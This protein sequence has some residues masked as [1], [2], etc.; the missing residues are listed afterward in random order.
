MTP[1]ELHKILEIG[2][3]DRV[4]FKSSINSSWDFYPRT[5]T[6]LEDISIEKVQK[7]IE[8]IR[9]RNNSAMMDDPLTFLQ[10]GRL[11]SGE[12][13][14][15][16]CWLLFMPDSDICTTIELGR[17]ESPT[18]ISDSVTLKEDL[19]SEVDG[20]LHFIRRHINKRIIITGEAENTERWDYP[21]EAIRELVI[22][23]I[24]HRDYT[25]PYDSIVK[26][27]DDRIEFFNPGSLPE[28]ISLEQLWSDQYVSMPRN[29]L[30]AEVFK[31]MGLIEKYGSGIRRVINAMMQNQLQP[32][33][34]ESLKNGFKVTLFKSKSHLKEFQQP[35]WLGEKL[36]N[37]LGDFRVRLFSD[38]QKWI[39]RLMTENP[40]ISLAEMSRQIG[41]SQTAV[42]KNIK[43]LKEMGAIRREGTAKKGCWKV[44][45]EGQLN[46]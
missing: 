37:R 36:G 20:V 3:T 19:I 12:S 7:T 6:R 34:F 4:E 29:K 27:F 30:I 5:D 41:I 40:A 42:E 17:F 44:L 8:A 39:M 1:T 14:T 38:N 23:M 16:A 46:E 31:A 2:V 28:D 25:S 10:K 43:K 26:V 15:H 24:L 35:E 18:I 13:V 22:N 11:I 33:E 45:G 32:P 9:R 21:L